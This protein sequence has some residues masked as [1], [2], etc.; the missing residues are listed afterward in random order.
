[1]PK[2]GRI[3]ISEC[4]CAECFHFGFCLLKFVF[5][6]ELKILSWNTQGMGSKRTIS[7]LK[8]LISSHKIEILFLFEPRVS[9]NLA[10]KII[11]SLK[12][13]CSHRV[14]ARVS[15]EGFGSYGRIVWRLVWW[16]IIN[17]LSIC[18][19]A[20][21]VGPLDILLQFMGVLILLK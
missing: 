13:D 10:N 21:N 3:S 2:E 6:M 5:L 8:D 18:V 15:L 1:M 11:C 17:N 7:V 12:F 19:Y 20:I 9:G 4:G 14:E 16:R